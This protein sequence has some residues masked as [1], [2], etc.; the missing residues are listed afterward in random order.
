[1]QKPEDILAKEECSIRKQDLEFNAL[2]FLKRW[3]VLRNQK[4]FWPKKNAPSGSKLCD[5]LRSRV[6]CSDFLEKLECAQVPVPENIVVTCKCGVAQ[7]FGVKG[8]S[9]MADFEDDEEQ[10]TDRTEGDAKVETS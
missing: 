1:M 6:Q 4:T 8:D 3:S 5:L 7:I 2:T 9:G 10:G